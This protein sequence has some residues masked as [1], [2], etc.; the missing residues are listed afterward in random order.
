MFYSLV[1]IWSNNTDTF[2]K[3]L[4]M[5]KTDTL[6][7]DVKLLLL[8]HVCHYA[9]RG[10]ARHIARDFMEC[11][12]LNYSYKKEELD[13]FIRTQVVKVNLN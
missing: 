12:L 3:I 6:S 1:F 13:T 9:E 10:L 11:M 8:A 5:E 7:T 4:T 2:F